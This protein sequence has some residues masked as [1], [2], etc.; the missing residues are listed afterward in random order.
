MPPHHTM[1]RTFF[2]VLV[3]LFLGISALIPDQ[4]CPVGF[5]D[6]V[7]ECATTEKALSEGDCPEETYFVEDGGICGCCPA[8]LR[9]LVVHSA[10]RAELIRR[11]SKMVSGPEKAFRVLA[12]HETKL[13][14]TE[15]RQFR[16]KYGKAPPSQPSIRAWPTNTQIP[17]NRLDL[18]KHSPSPPKEDRNAGEHCIVKRKKA[19]KQIHDAIEAGKD[20]PRWLHVPDCRVRKEDGTYKG[21]YAPYQCQGDLNTGRCYCVDP[22]TGIKIFGYQFEK[23]VEKT[24]EMN[25]AC[26]LKRNELAKKKEYSTLRCELNGNYKSLQCEKDICFCVNGTTIEFIGPFL[27]KSLM[28]LLPCYDP[29][30]FPD[31]MYYPLYSCGYH[32]NLFQERDEEH[33]AHGSIAKAVDFPSCDVDGTYAP[34]QCEIEESS[35]EC[36]GKDGKS[37]G[38]RSEDTVERNC[39]CARDLQF[40]GELGEVISLDCKNNGDYNEIQTIGSE[41]RGTT[42]CVDYLGFRNFWDFPI[43]FKCC[44][45]CAQLE[46]NLDELG[47][48]NNSQLPENCDDRKE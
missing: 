7:T 1:A 30:E 10:R 8:C 36:S 35:C 44:L 41:D 43:K 45:N 18:E 6:Q 38:Y 21:Y 15:Q 22:L 31:E 42:F 25:C 24:K 16:R 40:F 20:I 11:Y 19:L 46:C 29:E 23:E 27:P 37:I 39:Y 47:L 14:V 34:V 4:D 13:V 12:F 5:C 3:P 48:N 28:T 9:F 17:R 26:S 2:F 32:Y 33:A